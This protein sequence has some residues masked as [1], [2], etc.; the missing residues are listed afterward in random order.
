MII[1]NIWE[2][3][4]MFQ[5]T[6]QYCYSVLLHVFSWLQ[7]APILSTGALKERNPGGSWAGKACHVARSNHMEVTSANL[8]ALI[9]LVVN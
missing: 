5:T 8:V 4:Q 7:S 1:P 9:S 6:N 3:K 2:N